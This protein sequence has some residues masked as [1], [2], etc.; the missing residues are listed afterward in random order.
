MFEMSWYCIYDDASGGSL[1]DNDDARWMYDGDPLLSRG[2]RVTILHLHSSS[3]SSHEALICDVCLFCLC[4]LH[5]LC[6][7]QC[8]LCNP[9]LSAP[10]CVMLLY[11]HYNK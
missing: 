11:Y 5:F 6:A 9:C 10:T 2:Y 7:I 3:N 8:E 4:H 1:E